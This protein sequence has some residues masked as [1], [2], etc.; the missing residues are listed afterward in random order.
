MARPLRYV[1]EEGSLVEV[2]C[3]TIHGRFLFRPSPMFNAIIVGVLARAKQLHPLRISALVFLSNHFHLLVEV[4]DAQSL[5]DF[6][7]YF[8]S[9]LAR[10]VARL[11]GWSTRIFAT[12]YRA[13][14]VS[15]E[16]AA[17][18]ERFRYI[19][20]HGVKENL[21]AEIL[22]WPGV[23]MA[24]S[25]LSGEPLTGYW[26]DRTQEYAARRRRK[27]FDPLQYS[28]PEVLV[29]DP[30][31]CWK[32]LSAEEYRRRVAS[33]VQEIEEEAAAKRK[34]SGIQPLGRKAILAQHPHHCPE[35][36]KKSPAPRIHA[37]SQAVRRCFY[38]AYSWFVAAFRDAAAK[39]RAGDRMAS[40]PAGSFPPALPF[41]GG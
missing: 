20:S 40:F 29:L 8:N 3:R 26:I 1:P 19:L 24:H 5:S 39:L 15:D 37:A 23:H 34:Q 41:V 13:I 14:P 22:D 35:E 30:L 16:E 25:L 7:E 11:T 28:T 38:E 4:S 18:I 33:L 36:V 32:D 9:N 6:M 21:V 31:P 2:T 10:E 17:Q 12:R 27:E